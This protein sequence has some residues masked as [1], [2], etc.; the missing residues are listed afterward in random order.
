[1][2]ISSRVFQPPDLYHLTTHIL[3]YIRAKSEVS[4]L[5]P[6]HSHLLL[7]PSRPPAS[8]GR[9]VRSQGLCH[10][11]H[12]EPDGGRDATEAGQWDCSSRQ[13]ALFSSTI[14]VYTPCSCTWVHRWCRCLSRDHMI[15]TKW[16]VNWSIMMLRVLRS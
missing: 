12:S 13:R 11:H 4:P 6:D 8:P 7:P 3:S 10:G 16:V 2:A 5:S 15:Y 14:H 1:M 9:R